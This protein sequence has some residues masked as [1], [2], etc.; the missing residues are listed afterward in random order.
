MV[1]YLTASIM[2]N[3]MDFEINALLT[4][5]RLAKPAHNLLCIQEGTLAED[6]ITV[7]VYKSVQTK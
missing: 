3:P 1:S 4:R 5:N 2:Q 6:S 7:P